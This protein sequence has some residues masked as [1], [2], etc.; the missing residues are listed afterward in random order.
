MRADR[1]TLSQKHF[2]RIE[3]LM[4]AAEF[5]GDASPSFAKIARLLGLPLTQL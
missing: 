5:I 4:I 3:P 1:G 2:D